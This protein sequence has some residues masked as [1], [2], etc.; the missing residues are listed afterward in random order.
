MALETREKMFRAEQA[1][2]EAKSILEGNQGGLT[3]EKDQRVKFLL[4]E[5]GELKAQVKQEEAES[6]YRKEAADLDDWFNRP[7]GGVAHGINGDSDERKALA[8]LGWDLKN[9][10]LVAPTMGGKHVEMYPEDVLFGR[11]PEENPA[12]A[13]F[14]KQ[15]RAS[16]APEYKAAFLR[17][18]ELEAKAPAPGIAFGQLT[19]LERKALSEGTDTAGGFTV[20]PDT[21][22]E[23]MQRRAAMSVMRRRATV[24]TTNRDIYQAPAVAPH[25]TSPGI[26]SSGFVGGWVGETPAFS[27]TDPAFQMFS[28]S[29]KKLRVATKVSND[30]I[31]DSPANI[32]G[33]LA[34]DGAK[35]MAL[36]EDNGFIAGAGTPLEPLGILNSGASTVDV[37]GSTTDTISN[38]T[39]NVGSVPKILNLLYAVDAQYTEGASWLMRRAIEAEVHKLVDANGR[40]MWP[41]LSGSGFAPH[42]NELL[43]YPVD[44]SDFMP[45]DGTNGNKVIVFGD[46]SA[47]IIAQRNQITVSVLRERFAD[48]DQTGIILFERVGG[49]LWDSRAIRIGIV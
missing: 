46:L 45:D 24:R 4:K 7:V 18:M 16:F 29:I 21:S 42:T 35:N 40:F 26:Y 47:Y 17:Y 8:K 9:G 43:G 31:A 13:L 1:I 14:Y 32:L 36:V 20:P 41:V 33:F 28:I 25:A 5:A 2:A 19:E 22:A 37:E 49:A 39:S 12:R 44:N 30:L 3:P 23:I 34:Q 11:I 38:S 27:E 48:T 10:M 15:V 6:A